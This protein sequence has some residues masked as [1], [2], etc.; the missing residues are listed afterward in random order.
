LLEICIPRRNKFNNIDPED[1]VASLDGPVTGV[2]GGKSGRSGATGA[3]AALVARI[4]VDDVTAIDIDFERDN[5]DTESN[6]FSDSVL[7]ESEHLL[8]LTRDR[9]TSS[10]RDCSRRDKTVD[11]SSNGAITCQRRNSSTCNAG[12]SKSGEVVLELKAS[13]TA[14]IT[15]DPS[16][17]EF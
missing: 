15:A 3:D 2:R 12:F 9:N 8:G 7:S 5:A 10:G 4:G 14:F 11:T 17:E 16:M 13:V 6:V 1:V